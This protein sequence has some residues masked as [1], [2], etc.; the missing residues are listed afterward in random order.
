MLCLSYNSKAFTKQ[1]ETH[2]TKGKLHYCK[3]SS[4]RN[5][6]SDG[7]G[8]FH[9]IW[10]F[11][12]NSYEWSESLMPELQHRASYFQQLQP[13]AIVATLQWHIHRYNFYPAVPILVGWKKKHY[14]IQHLQYQLTNIRQIL[15][16]RTQE[17]DK[18]SQRNCFV[19]FK[20]SLDAQ[21]PEKRDS[22]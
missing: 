21:N 7:G 1:E 11:N 10:C 2:K 20:T 22:F 19:L 5:C 14:L 18:C 13:K 9:S 6:Q 15:I 17:E 12:C 4:K 3:D 8:Y 16:G